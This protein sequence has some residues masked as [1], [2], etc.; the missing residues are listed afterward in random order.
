[1]TNDGLL[2]VRD[3]GISGEQRLYR[4]GN[5]GLSVVNG[6]ALHYYTF[7]REIAVVR[8]TDERG[9]ND[10]RLVYTTPLTR[11]VEV[12][13]SDEDAST[14]VEQ[15]RDY[16]AT[17]DMAAIE[18]AEESAHREREASRKALREKYA[19]TGGTQ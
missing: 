19:A 12:F 5:W 10:F 11:D 13:Q 7:R 18:A 6:A 1:M 9:P 17:A 8:F 3:A 15:A 16:F 14:F 2:L 4:W